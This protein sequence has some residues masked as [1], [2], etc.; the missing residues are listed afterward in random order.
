MIK[1]RPIKDHHYSHRTKK[2]KAFTYWYTTDEKYFIGDSPGMKARKSNPTLTMASLIGKSIIDNPWQ[3][4]ESENAEMIISR[5]NGIPIN[6]LK[7]TDQEKIQFYEDTALVDVYEHLTRALAPDTIITFKMIAAWHDMVFKKIYPFAG[8]VRTVELSKGS[9][10]HHTEWTWRMSYLNGIDGLDRLVQKTSAESINDI[11]IISLKVAEAVPEF[12][13][14]HPF[15]E[16]NGR[17]GRLLGDI[18]LA[19]N[20]FPMI[21]MNL[22]TDELDYLKRV[23]EGYSKNYKPLEEIIEEKLIERIS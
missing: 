8:K 10:T 6:Y 21:G 13:F 9:S 7:T 22:M 11:E 4:W 14:I 12:L 17:I 20:N 16:G 19:K 1:S 3:E 15:R 18:I 2:G 23:R 5:T